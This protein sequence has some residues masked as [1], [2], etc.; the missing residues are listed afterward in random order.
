SSSMGGNGGGGGGA[1]CMAATDCPGTDNICV[2]RTC[3]N[4]VCGMKTLL[5]DM[6]IPSQ[7]YGDC[8]VVKCDKMGVVVTENDDTDLYDDGNACTVD[9]CAAGTPTNEVQQGVMCGGVGA[10][11]VCDMNASCVQCVSNT[12]CAAN[13]L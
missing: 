11:G 1:Q 5:S 4:G 2:V 9:Q 6:P 3:D 12:D 7:L 13:P 8:K 10:M